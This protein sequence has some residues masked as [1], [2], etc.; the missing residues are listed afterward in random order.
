ME[1][2]EELLFEAWLL[3][4]ELLEFELEL[5]LELDEVGDKLFLEIK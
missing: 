3:E 2:S 4:F 1:L 5:L